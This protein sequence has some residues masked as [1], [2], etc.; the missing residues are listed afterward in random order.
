MSDLN[1]RGEKRVGRCE[2]LNLAMIKR[3][4]YN[5]DTLLRNIAQGVRTLTL[6]FAKQMYNLR[7]N[8]KDKEPGN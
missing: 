1:E 2:H 6:N 8:N 7:L 3:R 5:Y 4:V